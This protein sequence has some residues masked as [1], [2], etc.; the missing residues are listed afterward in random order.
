[1]AERVKTRNVSSSLCEV[2]R[3]GRPPGRDTQNLE[4][5]V[6]TAV[7]LFAEHGYDATSMD[8]IAQ[9]LGIKKASLYHHVGS[10]E[11]LLELALDRAFAA[12]EG[13]VADEGT[14]DERAIVRLERITRAVVATTVG[15]AMPYVTLLLS[16]RGSTDAGR[17]ALRRRRRFDRRLAALLE[18]AVAE[19]DVRADLD[20]AAVARLFYGMVNSIVGWYRPGRGLAPDKLA[21]TVVAMLFDGVRTS[22][23]LC[24]QVTSPRFGLGERPTS[25][26]SS[27]PR[28]RGHDR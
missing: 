22:S 11:A 1:L 20:A 5:V 17:S 14:E 21:D 19:G 13:A 6:S 25:R 28:P 7:A 18:A 26:S 9:A 27:R 12:L 8:D 23:P 2:A 3:M 16:V 4:S 24:R 15:G 10:K